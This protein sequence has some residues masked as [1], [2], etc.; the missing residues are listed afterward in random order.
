MTAT[1]KVKCADLLPFGD[2]LACFD[3]ELAARDLAHANEYP[4]H[5]ANLPVV[6]FDRDYGTGGHFSYVWLRIVRGRRIW[7]SGVVEAL[8]EV[9]GVVR[10][11][12]VNGGDYLAGDRRVPSMLAQG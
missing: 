4:G 12:H 7:S 8:K 2:V 9:L 1:P 11:R 10:S 3:P 6:S 5:Q